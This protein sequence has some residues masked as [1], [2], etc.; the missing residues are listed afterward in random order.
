MLSF[1]QAK[2]LI[3]LEISLSDSLSH[4]YYKK[5]LILPLVLGTVS[6]TAVSRKRSYA[7]LSWYLLC[8][9]LYPVLTSEQFV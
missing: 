3:Y 8:S 7:W 5:L 4:L 1:F 9:R 2:P 6:I